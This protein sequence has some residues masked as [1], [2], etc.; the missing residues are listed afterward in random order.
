MRLRRVWR[1]GVSAGSGTRLDTVLA[2]EGRFD[3]REGGGS[4]RFDSVA[5]GR[6]PQCGQRAV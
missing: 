5:R 1:G 2:A 6:G 4:E 3:L